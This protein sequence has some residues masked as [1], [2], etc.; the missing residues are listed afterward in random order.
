MVGHRVITAYSS[1]PEETDDT[2]FITAYNTKVRDGIVATN[3]FP[4]GTKLLIEN[5]IYV[6]ED[7]TNSRYSYL[8]DIWMP[9][10]QEA[11]EWG[12]QILEVSI[13][14]DDID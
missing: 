11:I 1:C 4:K 5:R 8:I 7:K 14:V 9:S 3:E 12:R 6:V 2:P 13:I 10:K